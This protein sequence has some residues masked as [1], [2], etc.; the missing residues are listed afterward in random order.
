[1]TKRNIFI[2][3]DTHFGHKNILTFR[4]KDGSIFRNFQDVEEMNERMVEN[5]NRVVNDGDIVY[6]LGDVYFGDGWKVLP[7]LKGRLRLLLGNHDDGKDP[8]LLTRFQKIGMWRMFTDLPELPGVVL[9]HV[10]I[11]PTAF[12]NGTSKVKYN[13]HGHI[14]EKASPTPFH[15]NCCVEVQDYTPKEISELIP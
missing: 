1:M 7:R 15:I 12:E 11:D 2:V 3:S 8:R 9:T 13:L 10:P 5:C 14:H 6:H 4:D